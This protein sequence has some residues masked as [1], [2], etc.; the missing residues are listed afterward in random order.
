MIVIIREATEEDLE[1]LKSLFLITR[2]KTF[3]LQPSEKFQLDDYMESVAGEEVWVAEKN[4]I[5]TGFV[6]MWIQD[7]FIHNLFIHPNWQGLG[8]GSQLL[9][10]AEERLVSPMELKVKTENLKACKFYQ[11][12]GW[13]E[14]FI[15][16]VYSEPY[17]TYRK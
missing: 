9:K 5:I 15:N 6:S 7:N 3:T 17:F 11:K 8:I 14:V 1:Q 12:H 4:G 2:Q 16:D 10:K 13:Q